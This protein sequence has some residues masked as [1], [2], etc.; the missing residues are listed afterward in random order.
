M[1]VS[2]VKWLSVSG[3]ARLTKVGR[4]PCI[5]IHKRQDEERICALGLKA[6][7]GE[8]L[9]GDTMGLWQGVF[10]VVWQMRVEKNVQMDTLS[11]EVVLPSSGQKVPHPRLATKYCCRCMIPPQ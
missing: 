11:M 9:C 3:T 2:S 5:C 8:P 4:H 10:R 7:R 6:K 1:T